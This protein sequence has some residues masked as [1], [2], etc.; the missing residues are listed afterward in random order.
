MSEVE[1]FEGVG[2]DLSFFRSLA[3]NNNRAWFLERKEAFAEG[4]Q[5]PMAAL[6]AELAGKI[7]RSYPDCELGAPKVFR[8]NRDV[9]FSK[10][11]APYKTMV[12]G[13]LPIASKKGVMETPAAFYLQIGTETFSGAGCYGMSGDALAR[14]RTA[15]TDA[16]GP[17]VLKLVHK[18]EKAGAGVHAMETL[19]KVPRGFDPDHPAAELL[20]RKGLVAGRDTLPLELLPTRAFLDWCVAEARACAPLVRWLTFATA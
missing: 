16:R 12:S 11:K 1:R 19:K 17:E 10:D 5:R 8:I 3:R 4:W 9:R 2:G 18:L 13:V 20:K 7:D 14:Y 15:L 6:L